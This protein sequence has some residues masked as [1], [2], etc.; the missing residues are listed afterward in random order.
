MTLGGIVALI[1]IFI[2]VGILVSYL[3]RVISQLV[4]VSFTLGTIIAGVRAIASQIETVPETV[5]SVN[6]D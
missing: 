6:N 5:A 4:H 1:L 2:F 3:L